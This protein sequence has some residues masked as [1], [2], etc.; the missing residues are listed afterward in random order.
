M[1]VFAL[2]TGSGAHLGHREDE[3]FRMCSTFKWA[4][5]AAVLAQIDRGALALHTPVLFG[6]ADLVEF[7]PAARQH[8]SNGSMTVEALARAAVVQSD[9][10]A[11]NLLLRV[12][13]G[14]AGLTRFLREIGDRVTRIDREEPALNE[15][16]DGD[17]R[18]TTSPQAMAA[19][20]SGRC[21]VATSCR[22]LGARRSLAGC[23]T[24]RPAGTASAVRSE[25]F[26]VS[27][28]FTGTWRRRCS[29][30]AGACMP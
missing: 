23:V 21:S 2:D 18:D 13:G 11:A 17:P 9:S 14:P 7:A 12:V 28:T 15:G 6:P 3:R 29:R 5:A 19:A 16:A 24:A 4:V 22:V 25:R 26:L 8:V 27:T 20:R 1:G 30:P 10:T